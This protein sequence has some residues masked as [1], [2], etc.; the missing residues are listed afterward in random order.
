MKFQIRVS[1][2]IT[3]NADSFEDALVA[4]TS[5]VRV[6]SSGDEIAG[7]RHLTLN[8]TDEPKFKTG[9]YV[10]LEDPKGVIDPEGPAIV[11]EE[12]YSGNGGYMVEILPR[13]REKGDPDGLREVD[14]SQMR[15]LDPAIEPWW[16]ANAYNLP[17]KPKKD[18]DEG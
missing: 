4:A 15:A 16:R 1:G 14:E 2:W 13:A 7:P 18:D 6:L 9:D 8:V 10:M 5:H 12:G 3:L 11:L 17:P